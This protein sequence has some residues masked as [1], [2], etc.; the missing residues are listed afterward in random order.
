MRGQYGQLQTVIF[1]ILGLFCASTLPF[2]VN[3]SAIAQ[4]PIATTCTTG[5]VNKYI[6]KLETIEATAFDALVECKSNAVPAIV[7]ALENN[8]EKTRILLISALGAIGKQA[9]PVSERLSQLLSQEKRRSVRVVTVY[10]LTEIG[11]DGIP[12]VVS[13][14]QDSDWYIRSAAADALG[15]IGASEAIPALNDALKDKDWY[16]SS[17]VMRAIDKISITKVR[18]FPPITTYRVK[19]ITLS[20]FQ[21]PPV[22]C[23]VALI[24]AVFR[25]KC[26]S[27]KWQESYTKK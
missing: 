24:S 23:R 16:V 12:S 4:T 19:K 27:I 9:K 21:K 26:P 6:K 25:W 8:D 1:T 2:C 17:R 18:P 14:L 5:E 10:T 22:M 13:T 20:H 3:S 15:E 7:K 11:K